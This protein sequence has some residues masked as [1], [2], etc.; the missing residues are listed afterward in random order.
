M[1]ALMSAGPALE[2]CNVAGYNCSYLP[3]DSPRSFDEAMYILMCGTG[4]GFSVEKKYID[5]LPKVAE[6]FHQCDTVIDVY[7]SKIGWAKA[8]RQLI[9]LLYN[10]DIPKWTTHRVRPAGARLKTF[11]GRASGPE[12]LED[13][14]HFAVQTFTRAAGRQLSYS[15]VSRSYV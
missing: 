5:K 13:L 3:V 14:F 7:D 12:P 15:R 11:G 4:V 6:A 8:F 2:R 10:G 1:R 9:S